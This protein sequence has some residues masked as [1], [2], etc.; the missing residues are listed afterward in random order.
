MGRRNRWD[1]DDSGATG[2]VGGIITAVAIVAVV[3]SWI[4]NAAATVT[5]TSLPTKVA[6]AIVETISEPNDSPNQISIESATLIKT[7]NIRQGPGKDYQVVRVMQAG[8]RLRVVGYGMNGPSVWYKLD[9]GGW[10]W[11]ELVSGSPSNLPLVKVIEVVPAPLVEVATAVPTV[12]P[13][14]VEACLI[15]GNISYNTGEKIYHVPGQKYYEN[16]KIN[17][18]YGERWFC[19]EE[20]A[21]AAGWRKA[22][23]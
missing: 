8:S 20:D 12:M 1:E 9:D 5:G 6:T 10:V 15:K 13:T 22:R 16:T 11:S 17:I 21:Q 14:E 19:S 2:V 4:T 7:A 3:V 23:E 18:Q